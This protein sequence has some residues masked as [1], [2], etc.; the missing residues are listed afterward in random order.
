MRW[1]QFSRVGSQI[2][3]PIP[4]EVEGAPAGPGFPGPTSSLTMQT[5]FAAIGVVEVG[6]P[7]VS[8]SFCLN[9]L[10][11][12]TVVSESGRNSLFIESSQLSSL[13][14]SLENAAGEQT[15]SASAR[16]AAHARQAFCSERFLAIL[17][18]LVGIPAGGQAAPGSFFLRGER[19]TYAR[20]P[21]PFI[22]KAHY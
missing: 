16:P 13:R 14:S 1:F 19:P 4:G 2:S 8:G 10:T 21:R 12:N 18:S 15:V 11:S 3:I 7:R 17:I 9:A 5:S 20:M 6:V 22:T